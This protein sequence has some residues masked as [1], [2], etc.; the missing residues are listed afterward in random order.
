M[1]IL[2]LISES[3]DTLDT[4]L[5]GSEKVAMDY[6]FAEVGKMVSAGSFSKQFRIPGS[7]RVVGFF[8]D[9]GNVNIVPEISFHKKVQAILTEETIPVAIG[10][11]QVNKVFRTSNGYSEIELNFFAETPDLSRE[12]G[13]K[14]LSDLDTSELDHDM[15]R[16]NVIAGGTGWAYALTDRGYKL[17]EMGE[18]GT[19]QVLNTDT[20]LYS[21]EMTLLVNEYWLFNKIIT[22]A[23]FT[24]E[25]V[26]IK[27]KMESV[28]I[29]FVNSKFNRSNTQPAQFLFSAYL[30]SNLSV[31]A[32]ASVEVTGFTET[33][34]A[35]LD[36]N[37]TSGIYTAPYTGTFIFRVWGTNNPTASSGIPSNYRTIRLK[38]ATTNAILYNQMSAPS[39]GTLTKNIQSN[40]VTLFLYEDQQVIMEVSNQAAGV[41]EGGTSDPAL[42]TGWALVN[43]SDAISGVPVSV[44]ANAPNLKQMDLIM[45]IVRKYNLVVIPDRAIGKKI[46]FQ[47]FATFIGSGSERDWSQKLDLSVD[48]EIA[49]TTEYQ[50]KNLTFTYTQGN[51]AASELYK[52]EGKRVYGDYLI[53]GY[54]IDPTD[55]PNDF[56]QGDE[57]VQLIAMSTPCNTIGGTSIVVPKFVDASGEY[58]DPGLRYLFINGTADVALYDEGTLA[59]AMTTVNTCGHYSVAFP[60]INDEDLNFAPEVPLH[61]IESNPYNNL[62]NTYFRQY[63]N[64]LYSPSARILRCNMVLNTND[65]VNFRFSD[66]IWI[67]DAWWRLIKI[68]NYE[69]GENKSTPCEFIKL[70]DAQLDCDSTPYQITTGGI[71]QFQLPDE[72]LT[73][74]TEDC[75][76]RYGYN[77]SGDNSRCYAFGDGGSGDRPSRPNGITTEVTGGNFGLSFEGGTRAQFTAQMTNRS[78]I[79]PD[80]V[81][82]YFGGSDITI[83]K[84]NPNT[85]AV[86]EKIEVAE[87]LNGAF[88]GGKN[89]KVI[90][91]GLHIGGGW[92]DNDYSKVIGQSQFGVIQYIGEGNLSMLLSE[93]PILIEGK[94]HLEIEEGSTLNCILNVSL[95]QWSGGVIIDTRSTQFA[96][97]AYKVSGDAKK[98]TVHQVYDFG[99]FHPLTLNIDTTTDTNQHRLSISAAGIGHP[100]NGLKVSAS[101]IYTQIKNA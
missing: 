75:C 67:V 31:G 59:G 37:T 56:A 101:L 34:D 29:P 39:N 23:G 10:H 1:V 72:S 19:R 25:L 90:A 55:H 82:S 24:H 92:G 51:D 95:L 78:A 87:D 98:S 97:T 33:L 80:A 40:E 2:T 12:V 93:L 53:Q 83:G 3:G 27:P 32:G 22:E 43:T 54:T 52:K 85:L 94:T 70:I 15:T 57:A 61:L 20:P 14:M 28:W 88:V 48:C 6:Q 41:F 50:R 100:Y 64:E 8:G 49:P 38:D 84:G 63:L 71:V 76:R 46:L 36:F 47:P 96:F 91:P 13:S 65:I 74:G 11:V 18:V 77:W 42:G 45:D 58:N 86:G 4:D 81:F 26:D 9:L 79:S 68:S 21:G 17:S 7:D 5:L 66:K 16:E 44:A 89:V 60:T 35:N 73:F 62:F 30:T 99:N 69:V